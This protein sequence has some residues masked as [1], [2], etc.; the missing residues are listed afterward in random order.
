MSDPNTFENVLNHVNTHSRPSDLRI[1]D[2][3]FTDITGAPMHCNGTTAAAPF[4]SA[5]SRRR[6]SH[7]GST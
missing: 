2:M 6:S 1:T 4:S 5:H 3:R 7:P